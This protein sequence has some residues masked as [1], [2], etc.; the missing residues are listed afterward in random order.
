MT[1]RS[2]ASLS[3]LQVHSGLSLRAP[4][5]CITAGDGALAHLNFIFIPALL[6]TSHCWPLVTVYLRC[7]DCYIHRVYWHWLS[8]RI[9]KILLDYFIV[10]CFFVFNHFVV[11]AKLRSIF[12]T[13]VTQ[14]LRQNTRMWIKIKFHFLESNGVEAEAGADQTGKR[15]A[16]SDGCWSCWFWCDDK[17]AIWRKHKSSQGGVE[18]QLQRTRGRERTFLLGVGL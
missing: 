15:W 11:P 6:I 17:A 9:V 7:L 12:H 8:F 4:K 14:I 2:L 1:T 3:H 18:G 13:P 10:H 16:E 5:W